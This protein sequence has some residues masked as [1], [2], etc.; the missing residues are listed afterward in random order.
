MTNKTDYNKHIWG[1]EIIW[2]NTKKYSSLMM[3]ITE[4]EQTPYI[5]HKK[6]DKTLFI[7]Q[8][9]VKLI[10]EG[11]NKMLQSGDKYHIPPKLMHR[12]V[13]LEGDATILEVGTPIED[14]IIIV[15][16]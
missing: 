8:G 2:A 16:E 6:R 4:G 7:L 11:R 1:H 14:D 3:V 9:I 12:M 10:V 15:E 13:A 5:Y